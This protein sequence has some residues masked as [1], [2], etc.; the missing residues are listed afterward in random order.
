ML[1]IRGFEHLSEP[2]ASRARFFRRLGA[3]V[4]LALVF[5]TVSL[6]VGMAGYHWLGGLDWVDSDVEDGALVARLGWRR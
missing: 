4:G 2:V 3:N 5:I 6:A 1:G